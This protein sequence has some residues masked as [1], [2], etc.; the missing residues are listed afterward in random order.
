MIIVSSWYSK[1]HG[2]ILILLGVVQNGSYS[3]EVNSSKN[4]FPLWIHSTCW[5]QMIQIKFHVAPKGKQG[6]SLVT[7]NKLHSSIHIYKG[8]CQ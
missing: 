4:C 5:Y 3:L 1:L 7:G 6:K 8:D 2:N